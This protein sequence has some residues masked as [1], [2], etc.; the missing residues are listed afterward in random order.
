[1]SITTIYNQGDDALNIESYFSMAPLDFMSHTG[2]LGLRLTDYSVPRFEA[3]TTEVRYMNGAID[4][5]RPG[6]SNKGV[7]EVTFRCDKYWAI[8]RE[9]LTWKRLVSDEVTGANFDFGSGQVDGY[10]F[11][12][13]LTT[14]VIIYTMDTRGVQTSNGWKFY[15][16]FIKN[17]DSVKFSQVDSGS[18]IT[19]GATFVYRKCAPIS[20]IL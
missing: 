3:E 4:I 17:L 20:Y 9:L 18:P 8:Y 14:T 7:L 16:V 19:V 12:D 5:P 6:N 15:N 10:S 11:S 13:Y 1:M 2:A